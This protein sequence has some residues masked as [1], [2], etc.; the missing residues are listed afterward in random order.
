MPGTA[1]TRRRF[2]LMGDKTGIEEK[3]RRKAVNSR[4]Q[5]FFAALL[6]HLTESTTSF[7]QRVDNKLQT[8]EQNG[9]DQ[10]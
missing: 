1:D 8:G 5:E 10:R 6:R 2:T 7:W 4:L 9:R 3:V